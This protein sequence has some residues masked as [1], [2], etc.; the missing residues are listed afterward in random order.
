MNK[1]VINLYSRIA[2]YRHR[3]DLTESAKVSTGLHLKI[4]AIGAAECRPVGK[5]KSVMQIKS[6]GVGRI[7]IQSR[8][9]L[10]KYSYDFFEAVILHSNTITMYTVQSFYFHKPAHLYL[11]VF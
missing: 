8:V 6:G 4:A 10:C 11:P 7:K 3:T 9:G 1:T 5:N 2:L